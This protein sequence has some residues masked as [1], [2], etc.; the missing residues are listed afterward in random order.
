MERYGNLTPN[1]NVAK[2]ADQYEEMAKSIGSS[3][4]YEQTGDKTFSEY[5][6]ILANQYSRALIPVIWLQQVWEMIKL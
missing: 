6:L 2:I 1:S 5:I 3:H 4:R